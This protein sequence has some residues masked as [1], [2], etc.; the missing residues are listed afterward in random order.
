MLFFH[1]CDGVEGDVFAV[2]QLSRGTFRF[3]VIIQ[4]R[5]QVKDPS[6]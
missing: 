1:D 3:N 4:G 5:E 2:R 6:W